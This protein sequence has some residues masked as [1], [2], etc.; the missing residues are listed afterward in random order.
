MCFLSQVFI[1]GQLAEDFADGFPLELET[2]GVVH[3]PIQ[4]GI[5][6]CVITDAGIPLIGRQLTDH[7]GGRVFVAVIHNLHQV[8]TVS[9][10][11]RLQPPVIDD[12]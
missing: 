9:R 10:L 3:Q 7:Q 11:Q 4:D 1:F 5:G 12:Q 6:Q 8:V 2:V